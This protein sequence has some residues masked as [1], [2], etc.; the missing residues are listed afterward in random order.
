MSGKNRCQDCVTA[1]EWKGPA[2]LDAQTD[3]L[4]WFNYNIIITMA[5]GK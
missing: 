3:C 1:E 2:E 5:A 4:E